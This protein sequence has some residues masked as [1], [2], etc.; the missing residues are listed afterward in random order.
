MFINLSNPKTNV[1][2]QCKIGFSWTVFFFGFFPTIFRG[3]WKWLIAMLVVDVILGFPSFGIASCIAN[4]IFA[5]I[6]NKLYITDLLNAGYQPVNDSD[7][8]I[9]KQNGF[10]A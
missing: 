6:Y 3:D 8:Q 2:K 10:I 9:L 5:F 7:E 1:I 4:I